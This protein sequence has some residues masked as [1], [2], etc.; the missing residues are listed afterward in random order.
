MDG[1]KEV[2]GGRAGSWVGLNQL[3]KNLTLMLRRVWEAGR[4]EKKKLLKMDFFSSYDLNP[5]YFFSF[6]NWQRST[7]IKQEE[8]LFR[9]RG[10]VEK[11]PA[12]RGCKGNREEEFLFSIRK[13]RDY[14]KYCVFIRLKKKCLSL[15]PA[16]GDLVTYVYAKSGYVHFYIH[17]SYYYFGGSNGF[18]TILS[19][20][21]AS[22]HSSIPTRLINAKE[23]YFLI[24]PPLNLPFFSDLS[25]HL[26]L[27]SRQEI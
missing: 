27:S 13:K 21:L 12:Q 14:I 7:W 16:F 25:F 17:L 2:E 26:Q 8:V 5:E 23:N 3:D 15:L 6:F 19:I 24:H 10:R 11:K 18:K 1:L 20:L 4:E 22:R 9:L